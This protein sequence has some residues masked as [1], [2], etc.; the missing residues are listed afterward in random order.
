MSADTL[1]GGRAEADHNAGQ[2]G[3]SGVHHGARDVGGLGALGI[4]GSAP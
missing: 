1:Q 4:E 3:A 2:G